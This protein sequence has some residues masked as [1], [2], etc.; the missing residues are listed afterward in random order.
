M[1]DLMRQ[2]SLFS[3]CNVDIG[4][5]CRWKRKGGGE[6]TE[7]MLKFSLVLNTNFQ[8][9]SNW[10]NRELFYQTWISHFPLI[11]AD[12]DFKFAKLFLFPFSLTNLIL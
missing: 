2:S 9:E 5:S 10:I 4:V 6:I 12:S 11:P 8:T 7:H 1:I 3:F